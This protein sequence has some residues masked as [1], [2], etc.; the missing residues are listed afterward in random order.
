MTTME[1]VVYK[2][3]IQHI[4]IDNLQFLLPRVPAKSAFEKFEF[5]DSVVDEFRRFAT[6]K[7]VCYLPFFFL[8]VILSLLLSKNTVSFLFTLFFLIP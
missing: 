8:S 3:D 6:E 1:A 4:I 2:D 7:N 5:Q